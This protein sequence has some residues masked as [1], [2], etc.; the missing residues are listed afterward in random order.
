MTTTTATTKTDIYFEGSASVRSTVFRS[1][2]LQFA[3]QF[4]LATPPHHRFGVADGTRETRLGQ[5]YDVKS[6]Q[7]ARKKKQTTVS[8]SVDLIRR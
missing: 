1:E 7:E 4:L 5:F 3:F 2:K 6:G 8:R